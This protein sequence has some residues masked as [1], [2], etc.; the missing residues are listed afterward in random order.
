MIQVYGQELLFLAPESSQSNGFCIWN[1]PLLYSLIGSGA[2][3]VDRWPAGSLLFLP[4]GSAF[5]KS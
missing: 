4:A 5:Y 3:V 2:G 1:W